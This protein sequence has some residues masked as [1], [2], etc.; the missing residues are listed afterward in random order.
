MTASLSSVS[1]V[2]GREFRA[3]FATPLAAIFLVVFLALAGAMTFFVSGFFARGSA[4]MAAFFTWMPWLFLVLLPA[5][6]MRLWAEERRSGTIELLMTMPVAPWTI[7]L[8]KF[9]AGWAFTGVA[10]VLTT[11]LWVTVNWLGSPDNGVIA[12]GYLG[13]FLM[14]GAFLAIA[15]CISTLTKNQVIAFI[16][17]AIV[18][19]LLVTA[20]LEL[21][22]GAIRGWAPYWLT[23]AVAALSVLEHFQRI[24][25]GLIEAPTLIFFGSL[26]VLA[27]MINTFL[28]DLKKAQ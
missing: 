22:L 26:I 17:A 2:F 20:G 10:L 23:E 16:S 13:T 14:A 4:D 8:G 11:P 1:V 6:G 5:I 24:T 7:V 21:V 25:Q 28:V 27:L 18:T 19:F 3:Y 12:A 9:L 15:A